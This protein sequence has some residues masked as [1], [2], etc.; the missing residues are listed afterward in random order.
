MREPHAASPNDALTR[1]RLRLDGA[2]V[3]LALNIVAWTLGLT[4]VMGTVEMRGGRIWFESTRGPGPDLHLSV[5]LQAN[6][7]AARGRL[8]VTPAIPY[9]LDAM[10][11]LAAVGQLEEL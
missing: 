9:P 7:A 4:K 2:I 1:L 8:K 11:P 3:L 6:G 5:P 10:P